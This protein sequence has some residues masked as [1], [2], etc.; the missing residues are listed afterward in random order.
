MDH[1]TMQFERFI[2][3]GIMGYERSRALYPFREQKE[4]HELISENVLEAG[5]HPNAVFWLGIMI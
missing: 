5:V 2:G 1:W 4:P 3:S